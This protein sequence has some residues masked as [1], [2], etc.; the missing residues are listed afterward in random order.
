MKAAAA[1]VGIDPSLVERAARLV[2]ANVTAAP[3]FME[4]LFGG[5][6]R[7]SGEARFPI[8]LDEAGVAQLL[9]AI[10]IGVGQPGE[11]HSS[12]LGLTWRSSD[13]G[14]AV[15]SLTAETDHERTSVKLS[16]I[17]GVHWSLSR[18]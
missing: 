16:S 3:S 18:V 13:L 6:A 2:P 1:Q 17:V 11:G 4:R 8:V 9:S 14:G 12:A 10:R 15:L 7:Y 5:R